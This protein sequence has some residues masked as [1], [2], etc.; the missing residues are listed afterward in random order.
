MAQRVNL[1]VG[2]SPTRKRTY[3][4][5]TAQAILGQLELVSISLSQSALSSIAKTKASLIAITLVK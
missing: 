2:G 3:I 1:G 4:A 5:K